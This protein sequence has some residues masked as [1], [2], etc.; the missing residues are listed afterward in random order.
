[1]KE[2]SKEHSSIQINGLVIRVSQ[3]CST[4]EKINEC[5]VAVFVDLRGRGWQWGGGRGEVVVL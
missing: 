4:E 1:M 3:P 2:S 5:S